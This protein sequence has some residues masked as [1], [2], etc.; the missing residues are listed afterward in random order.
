[1]P[2]AVRVWIQINDECRKGGKL[3]CSMYDVADHGVSGSLMEL[4]RSGRPV[5]PASVRG[6][7]AQ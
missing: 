1:M 4:L 6:R 5:G 2:L 7:I 3:R